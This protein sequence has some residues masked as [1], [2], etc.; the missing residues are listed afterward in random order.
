MMADCA[1]LACAD[2]CM[3]MQATHGITH[4]TGPH[5]RLHPRLWPRGWELLGRCWSE[6]V[7]PL[8]VAGAAHIPALTTTA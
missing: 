6:I 8:P 2:K 7:W 5:R 4:P 3:A 1:C